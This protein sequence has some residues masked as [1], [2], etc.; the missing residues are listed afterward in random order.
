[1]RFFTFLIL[2]SFSASLFLSAQTPII[3]EVMASNSNVIADEDGSYEDW[4]ELYNPGPDSIQLGGYGISDDYDRPFRWVF[5]SYKMAPEEYLLIWASGKDRYQ[6]PG[7]M[8]NGFMRKVYTGIPGTSVD[9]LINHPSFPD[10]PTSVNIIDDHFQS[11][12]DIGDNYGQHIYAWITPPQTGEYTF[13][14]A[15]DDNCRLFLS[16][17]E[18][19]GNA[20]LIAE[21]PGWT[22]VGEWEKYPEQRSEPIFLEEG[23][24][25]Y[26]SALMKEAFGGDFVAVRWRL[27]DGTMEEPLS[28]EHAKVLSLSSFHTNFRISSSGEEIILTAPDG[29]RVDEML[30]VPIP[31]NISYGRP[32]DLPS[33]W[34]YF[35]QPTPGAP[36]PQSG[37]QEF[38][39]PPLIYPS[40]GVYPEAITIEISG[41]EGVPIFYTTDGSEPHANNGFLYTGPFELNEPAIV[42]AI[43]VSPEKRSSMPAG[44]S[45]IFSTQ[46]TSSFSSNLPV[47]VIK[48]YDIPVSPGDRT[49]SY[50][51]L[52]EPDASG[53]TS[54]DNEP[55]FT[56]RV[57]INIR[58][59]SSQSFPKKGFGFHTLNE[60]NSNR[61]VELLGMPEE[62][63][64]ILHGPYSD[65]SLMRNA[66]SYSLGSDLGHYSPRTKFI[67]LFMHDGTGPLTEGRYHGVYLLV[68]RIKIAPGR[69]EIEDLS[70]SDND[71]PDVSGGYI[72]K[73][74]RLNPGEEGFRTDRGT[75]FVYVRPNEA[76]ISGPQSDYLLQYL[77]D[78]ETALFGPNFT[79]PEIGYEA[80]IDVESFIDMHLITELCKEIDGYRLST[81]FTKD[82][83]GKIKSGPLWDFNL[84]LGNA[85]YLEGWDPVGWYYETITTNQYM[86]GWYNRLFED[87]EF[88]RRYRERYR[89]LRQGPFSYQALHQKVMDYYHLLEEPAERNFQRWNILGE[90][91][92]PNWFIADTYWEEIEWMLNWIRE[93]LNWMDSQL[94]EPFELIH[95]WNFN[96]EEDWS[97]PTF[98]LRNGELNIDPGPETEITFGSGQGFSGE[99]ARL[100]DEAGTH[101]RVNNPIGTELDWSISTEGFKD[102]LLQYETRRSGSGANRQYISYTLDGE[103][104]IPFDTVVI[105]DEAQLYS[106]NFEAIED[107]RDN[108]NFRI[109]VEIGYEDDGTGGTVGNNRF[110]NFTVEG[111]P[112]DDVNLPPSLVSDLP[113][114]LKLI[115]QAEATSLNLNDFFED[116]DGDEIFY[117]AT[118]SPD[119][120]ALVNVTD[121][122]LFV[123]GENT[124]AATI[125]LGVSDPFNDAVFFDFDLLIYPEAFDAGTISDAYI[126]DF[127]SQDEPEGSFPTHMVFLQTN[128]TDP[129]LSSDFIIPY[130][131]PESDFHSSEEDNFGFPYR[132]ER[133]TRINGLGEEGISLINTGRD[134]DLG[135]ILFAVD[136]RDLSDAQLSWEA[137]TIRSNSRVYHVR[138]QFR[139]GIEEPWQDFLE[140]GEI[141]EYIRSEVENEKEYF[142]H[143][144]PQEL[145]GEE[146]LQFRWVY[147][148]TGE[149][150]DDDSGARDMIGFHRMSFNPGPVST[151]SP[152]DA[153]SQNL[154]LFPNP[155]TQN[156]VFFNEELS[157]RIL[158]ANGKIV[159]DFT[160][161]KKLEVSHLP[162]GLYFILTDAGQA[163][164]FLIIR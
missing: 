75:R 18:E 40:S 13:W 11:P 98:T 65:K 34:V 39:D 110:D 7:E 116:A 15:G 160:G 35:D 80:Y 111:E 14:V 28:A 83:N 21:V 84:A 132:N 141:V 71:L 44:A 60:D 22:N 93:R 158:S 135:S 155:V 96:D 161:T 41:E 159:E 61:K 74:D 113:D 33:E 127:W 112:L 97:S 106:F 92:W 108:P 50:I 128:E 46:E 48:Q 143:S 152:L 117:E 94:G 99:N 156:K 82:R 95:Y 101:L 102:I 45:Y 79:D 53:Y 4:I 114:P 86:Y 36:N 134:R 68:E 63:N 123:T 148:F 52:Y 20:E 6:A 118:V 100:G 51:S 66:V 29:E 157:G 139:R 87:P 142:E 85:N 54:F 2:F 43:S 144:I 64:W 149:R 78:F 163:A 47:M 12:V 73:I 133:R 150:L 130:F 3:N 145:L 126:F 49:T 32:G 164:R 1:M 131:I 9:D 120:S 153:D 76:T 109:R 55:D 119:G 70:P 104:Y 115:S 72:F 147:Y 31:T 5:P 62:H 154:I 37:F 90:Y 17:D 56:G 162:D 8:V 24:T 30:P 77:N 91:I 140:N 38:I 67:E 151:E 19:E 136:T 27:P 103:N 57:K 69:V 59:S 89:S 81:F 137:S 124:G 121:S 10:Y 129:D 23:K 107:V 26:L 138:L 16:S 146:Y 88:E 58:G 105:I 122:I 25:Y 42:R 125:S